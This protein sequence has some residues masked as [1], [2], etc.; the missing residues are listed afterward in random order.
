MLDNPW[1]L[2][3]TVVTSY[4][5]QHE[6]NSG[7]I[8]SAMLSRNQ[9]ILS[10][11]SWNHQFGSAVVSTGWVEK[12]ERHN[13]GMKIWTFQYFIQHIKN[14]TRFSCLWPSI[15]GKH[16]AIF[17]Y[18]CRH[19]PFVQAIGNGNRGQAVK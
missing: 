5:Q 14:N 10:G 12:Q 4:L 3:K 1:P 2:Y 17:W 11:G 8:S 15:T 13:F 16:I 7:S 18:K 19:E 9:Q 6:C